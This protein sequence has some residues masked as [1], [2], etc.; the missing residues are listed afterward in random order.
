MNGKSV[1]IRCAKRKLFRPN[2]L[3]HPEIP[4]EQTGIPKRKASRPTVNFK[5]NKISCPQ[6]KRGAKTHMR[7]RLSH[8]VLRKSQGGGEIG[9]WAFECFCVRFGIA[10]IS[11]TKNGLLQTDFEQKYLDYQN[12]P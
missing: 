5:R 2:G 6:M 11:Y 1:S 4:G 9:C 7:R 8:F 3:I 12:Y 10:S